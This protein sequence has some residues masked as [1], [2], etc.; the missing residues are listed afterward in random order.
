MSVVPSFTPQFSGPNDPGEMRRYLNILTNV[1]NLIV[2]WLIGADY[3]G[4]VISVAASYTVGELDGVV[5][6]NAGGGAVTITVPRSRWPGHQVQIVK[7]D[8]TNNTVTIQDDTATLLGTLTFPP[9]NGVY[10]SYTAYAN[11]T[12]AAVRLI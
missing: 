12:N 11:A 8:A 5:E 2:A 6:V 4:N 10:N 1:I 7:I 9:V 3:L